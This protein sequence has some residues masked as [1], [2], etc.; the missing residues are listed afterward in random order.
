MDDP[1]D[2]LLRAL[3]D[4]TRRALLDR[5][6]DK[7]GLR[8]TE[9]LQGMPQSRQALS[10]HLAMLEDAE[11]LVPVW[12]GREKLHYLNPAPLQ[13]LPTR[14]VT[15]SAREDR[16][17]LS[18]LRAALPGA[19]DGAAYGA[20]Y[21]LA[22]PAAYGAAHGAAYGASDRA[23]PA[24][25]ATAAAE[26]SDAITSLLTRTPAPLLQ[27][28][29]V[30]QALALTAAIAY[31]AET[32]H[33]VQALLNALPPDAGYEQP[34]AGG[35]SLVE[36]LAHLADIETL[37]WRP[38]FERILAEIR[39][40]LPGV[41]GDKLAAESRSNNRPWRGAARRFIA[42]RKQTL[43]ALARFDAELLRRPVVFAGARTRAGSVLAA[44]VAHDLDHRPALAERWL[45]FQ[46]A[47][48]APEK[49]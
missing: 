19:A 26:A 32:A 27:G 2:L 39:P 5:L 11:L 22:Y 43:A 41:D 13:A 47:P 46:Q 25:P 9:L 40:S 24:S 17:A 1:L 44:A 35:F 7:P 34:P 3:S 12:R 14:W 38:R 21:G 42:Q 29:P 37:G 49:R 8:L 4:A 20:A 10:K 15:A 30:M 18:A 45:A 16:A 23:A 31:M 36:H 33:A 28:Q 6:R 48:S